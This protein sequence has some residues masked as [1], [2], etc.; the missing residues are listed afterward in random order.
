MVIKDYYQDK[1]YYEKELTI[2][3]FSTL[4]KM[5]NFYLLHDF[6]KNNIE[7]ETIMDDEYIKTLNRR[8][9]NRKI[10]K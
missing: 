5:S 8:I 2:N 4:F 1:L 3:E 10:Q 9:D 7:D 6:Y